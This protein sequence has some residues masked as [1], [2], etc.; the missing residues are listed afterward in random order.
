[1]SGRYSQTSS[2]VKL[3]MGAT[4]RTRVSVICQSTVCAERRALAGRREGVHAVFEDVEIERAQVDDGELVDG[5]VDA[6]K[7]EGLVPAEDFLGEF[8]GAGE[9]VLIEWQKFG[10]GHS[11]ARGIESVEIAEQEA[12][13]VAQLA[14][15]LGAALHQVFAGGHVFAEVDGGYPETNDFAAHAF[16]DVDGIDAVAEGLGHGA[17]LLVEC[18]AGGGD[19]RVGRAAAK[20]DRREQRG[21]EPAAVLIAAFEVEDSGRA[22]LFLEDLVDGLEIWIG[23]ADGEPACAGVEPDVEDVGL[24]AERD[25]LRNESTLCLREADRRWAWCAR[26][27][28]LRVRTGR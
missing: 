13:G 7:F 16:G 20:S 3:R 8:A 14:I 6:V 17:A 22:F 9:H 11:I 15:E 4:R 23:F 26:L 25:C 18:P 12:E 10:F 5:L 19:V 21:V 27:R 2:A 24:L 1:M 28:R